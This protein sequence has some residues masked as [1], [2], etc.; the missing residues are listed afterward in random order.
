VTQV[1]ELARSNP[2]RTVAQLGEPA[3]LV[4]EITAMMANLSS[5]QG[6]HRRALALLP[7]DE[8][9]SLVDAWYDF[10]R[11]LTLVRHGASLNR[12]VTGDERPDGE[13]L[14][15]AATL[16]NGYARLCE[17]I[18]S[19]EARADAPPR[20]DRDALSERWQRLRRG[21]RHLRLV[22]RCALEHLNGD[23]L[24][25]VRPLV[26][27]FADYLAAE[28]TLSRAWVEAL[29]EGPELNLDRAAELL[30]SVE[31]RRDAIEILVVVAPEPATPQN[32]RAA[33]ATIEEDPVQRLRHDV[34]YLLDHYPELLERCRHTLSRLGSPARAVVASRVELVMAWG[35]YDDLLA[36]LRRHFAPATAGPLSAQ[37][38]DDLRRECG[39]A[40]TQLE[41]VISC[42]D[43]ASDVLAQSSAV[44]GPG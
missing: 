32:V 11:Q 41:R 1:F 33:T 35:R 31:R 24:G 15:L 7:P 9:Q 17:E 2:P 8:A 22:V 19:A 21:D 23:A 30:T 29:S 27:M 20:A 12:H 5:L 25:W 37:A 40:A 38:A 4:T 44:T 14:A 36:E 42:L 10:H 43:A 26:D 16:P 6:R 28:Q 34:S 3:Q 13:P 18:E 39:V